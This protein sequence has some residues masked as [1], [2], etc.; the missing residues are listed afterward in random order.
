MPANDKLTIK[1]QWERP[2]AFTVSVID[3]AGRVVFLQQ[4]PAVREYMGTIP[5]SNLPAGNYAVAIGSPN[6]QLMRKI[7]V[8][9]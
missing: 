7:V 8:A 6:A 9:D 2:E 1:M 4:E 5:V 3:M